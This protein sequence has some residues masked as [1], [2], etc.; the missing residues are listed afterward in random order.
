[1]QQAGAWLEAASP[2]LLHGGISHLG[3]N[4]IV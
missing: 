4:L 1:M 2:L 3:S